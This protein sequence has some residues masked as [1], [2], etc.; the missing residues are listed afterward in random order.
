MKINRIFKLALMSLLTI[1]LASVFSGCAKET[2]TARNA[3][4]SVSVR[5]GHFAN[6]THSQAL[7]GREEGQFQKALG[8]KAKIDWKDLLTSFINRLN[9]TTSPILFPFCLFPLIPYLKL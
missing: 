8:D 7:I 1:S 9:N 3:D 5:V 6:I 2:S 4:G